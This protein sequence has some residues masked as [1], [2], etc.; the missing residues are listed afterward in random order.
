MSDSQRVFEQ[1]AEAI[2]KANHAGRVAERTRQ[3]IEAR[4]SERA[5]RVR[6]RS[7]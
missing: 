3:S 1:L 4:E 2:A 6:G 7:V 5:I